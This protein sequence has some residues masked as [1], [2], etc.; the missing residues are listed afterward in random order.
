MHPPRHFRCHT[1]V[2]VLSCAFAVA[3]V[4]HLGARWA[5]VEQ[6]NALS[7]LSDEAPVKLRNANDKRP[8][9]TK[10]F[11]PERSNMGPCPRTFGNVMIFVAVLESSYKT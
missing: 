3:L 1:L 4:F 8:K 6:S 10:T 5:R 9:L 7:Y 11:Y 2:Y